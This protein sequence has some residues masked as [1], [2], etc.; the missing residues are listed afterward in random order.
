MNIKFVAYFVGANTLTLA[1][2]ALAAAQEGGSAER[3]NIIIFMADDMGYADAG[4]TGSEYIKTPNLDALAAAGVVFTNGH[5]THPFSGPSRAGLLSGR[6]QHRF[7]FEE[8][9]AYDPANETLGI[10][11]DEVLFPAR[12]QKAGYTT[13][14]IGKWH[15]GAAFPFH[16]NN[17]GFDYFYGFLGGGHDYFRI[18]MLTVVK[19]GY[20]QPLMRNN[21]PAT[22]DG[23]LTDALSADAAQ[24]V[25]ENKD[26]P[27]ML[28][29]AY[30]A[31]HGPLQAP[32]EDIARYKHI[33]DQKRRVYSAMVDVMDLGIGKVVETLKRNGLYENTIIFFLSDNG[34]PQG[35]GYSA[36]NGS[37]NG[38][39]RGG[40]GQYY[41]G[42]VHVPFMACWPAKI[43][44]GTRIDYP[45]NS[46]DISRT[47]VE[48]AG[49]DPIV[50]NEMDG[51]NLIPYVTGEAKGAPHEAIF[52][53]GA[54]GKKWA[55]LS[56][57]NVKYVKS[58]PE[59][60]PQ[61][62][63]LDK[64]PS[65]AEDKIAKNSKLVA[66]LQAE[67]DEWNMGNKENEILL[68]TQYHTAREAFFESMRESVK[69]FNRG[70]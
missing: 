55:M 33:E 59:D 58:K 62:Y 61:L 1:P 65:E 10:S 47:A 48:L 66:R 52:W 13:G 14:A 70:E 16:P 11:V 53:R 50:G 42:G 6:Y 22:F 35:Q 37:N 45:V 63:F 2:Q 4:F 36:Y 8:N 21:Q 60:I 24:F 49:G 44:A 28:Y 26:N 32:K 30:N 27:F 23:Y 5:T 46:L 31:P 67:W 51:V 43:E 12:I 54:N 69:E 39:F 19:E 7:G 17:R 34:G 29:V 57:D 40:K 64:D 18:N 38:V 20:Q 25:E 68:Y 56:K 15:L 41:E 9:P 3:P